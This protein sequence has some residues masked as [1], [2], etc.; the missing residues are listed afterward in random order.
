[1]RASTGLGLI[2]ITCALACA[3]D[4]ADTTSASK[5]NTDGDGAGTQGPGEEPVS[6]TDPTEPAPEPPAP[7]DPTD[8]ETPPG[9]AVSGLSITEVA[10]FQA[11]KVPVVKDGE[12]VDPKRRK[13]PVVA[14]RPGIIRV[15]VQPESGFEARDVTAELRLVAGDKKFPIIRETKRIGRASSDEDPKSTFNLEVPAE[16][17]PDGVTFQVSLTAPDGK[18]LEDGE[19]SKS[20]FPEDGS[21]HDLATETSGKLRVVLVPVKYE[22]DG[23][24][25]MPDIGD[26]QMARYK[27][28]LVKR[29]PATE[30]EVTVREPYTFKSRIAANG[31]GWQQIL[32]EMTQL[33]Q[34]DKAANDVYYYGIFA[35]AESFKQYCG[36]GCV[37]GLSMVVDENSPAMRASV[38]IG[39]T[40]PESADTL[41]H[42][43]GHAHGREHAPCGGPQGVDRNYPYP[44][45]QLGAWGYDILDKLFISPTKGRD[46]MGYCP[47]QWV[48]DYTYNALFQRIAI[49]NAT[50][51]AKH[52]TPSRTP[53]SYR[54]ALVDES[55]DLD[56]E[57]GDLDLDDELMG[58]FELPT[59]YVA[60][61]GAIV[62]T[63]P[64]R[65]FKFDH[66]PGGFLFVPKE[67]AKPWKVVRVEGFMKELAR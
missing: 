13:A 11:V 48:S 20:R 42:E 9:P 4:P 58:G 10:V 26:Q 50:K 64:A 44:Q 8:P 54:V 14:N 27:N 21:F 1:M 59:R 5:S 17:F 49:V 12:V 43:I 65:F 57:G 55:G 52:V 63:R 31:G 47:N 22:G 51:E 32:R 38:G 45:A 2:A 40:G 7:P 23:S 19:R 16:S 29:Y 24:G 25:R 67:E 61:T 15:Y 39:F 37:T 6:V 66:L 34:Q 62:A 3:A 60:D 28:V 18:P 36:G 41:A 35:P 30:V 53:S 56:W 33:R 46:M